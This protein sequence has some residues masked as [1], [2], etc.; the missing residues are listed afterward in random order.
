MNDIYSILG[1]V[2]V[3]TLSVHFIK[4]NSCQ[5][6]LLERVHS[7]DKM[8]QQEDYGVVVSVGEVVEQWQHAS[9]FSLTITQFWKWRWLKC[10]LIINLS[11]Q[12]E[13][14]ETSLNFSLPS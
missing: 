6:K 8:L 4:G 10:N 1:L 9:L 13:Q 3:Y 12:W 14:E 11:V 2:T 5:V 7:L